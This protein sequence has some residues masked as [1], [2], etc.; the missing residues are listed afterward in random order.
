[1]TSYVDNNVQNGQGYYYVVTAVNSSSEESAYSNEAVAV[2]PAGVSQAATISLAQTTTIGP[3]APGVIG[4]WPFHEGSG[5]IVHDVS[6][7]GLNGTV[8]GATWIA[9][10]QN[11]ALSFYGSTSFVVTPAVALANTFTVSAWVNPSGTQNS[12]GRIAE[13]QYNDG[14]Y[15]GMNASGSQ[16]KW[17][18]NHGAGATGVCGISF[19]CAEGGAVM[20]GWHL[21]TGTFDGV[22]GRLY[23]DGTLVA[24]ETFTAPANTNF[25]L[26]IGRWYAGSGF[27][28]NG[29]IDQVGLYNRALTAAEVAALFL[30]P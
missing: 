29:G 18:V 7:S 27:G 25:P 3:L 26:Y 23:V 5:T 10:Q 8:N 4:Y 16:Y 11:W 2:V 9:G 17:I 24:S 14:F 21:V 1:L 19:G 20:P 12:Y 22:T 6:G 30:S 13:T 15:L 28:W